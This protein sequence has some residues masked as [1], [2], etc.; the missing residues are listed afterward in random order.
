VCDEVVAILMTLGY[1]FPEEDGHAEIIDALQQTYIYGE[2]RPKHKL[3]VVF[4]CD[5]FTD[6]ELWYG[7]TRAMLITLHARKVRKYDARMRTQGW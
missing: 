5:E 4:E 7:A 6:L 3:R 2:E 1:E